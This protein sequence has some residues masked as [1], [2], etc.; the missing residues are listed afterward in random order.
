MITWKKLI[1]DH[2]SV[3]QQCRAKN[4]EFA[5]LKTKR[6]SVTNENWKRYEYLKELMRAYVATEEVLQPMIEEHYQR[7]EAEKAEKEAER[8]NQEVNNISLDDHNFDDELDKILSAEPK[9]FE[10]RRERRYAQEFCLETA[11]IDL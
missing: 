4:C 11:H 3:L 9:S 1:E 6:Q 7:V 5:E 8:V 10:G 2:N